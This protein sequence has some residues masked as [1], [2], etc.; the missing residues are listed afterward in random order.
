MQILS[1]M[2]NNN[3][4]YNIS[5]VSYLSKIL[6]FSMFFLKGSFNKT[7]IFN[8]YERKYFGLINKIISTGNS[9]RL[10]E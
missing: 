10:Y 3:I 8:K 6:G 4:H 5:I 2:E 7:E 1:I 9:P